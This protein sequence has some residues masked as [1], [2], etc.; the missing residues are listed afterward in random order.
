MTKYYLQ[1]FNNRVLEI[2]DK[3]EVSFQKKVYDGTDFYTK[4]D[5][6]VEAGGEIILMAW[7]E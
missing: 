7:Y 5:W 4:Y 2:T 1:L 3:K 6:Y